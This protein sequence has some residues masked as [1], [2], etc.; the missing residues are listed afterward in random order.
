MGKASKVLPSGVRGRPWVD[1]RS[2]V[3]S[4]YVREVIHSSLLGYISID[5]DTHGVIF[6]S[7]SKRRL[8]AITLAE[9]DLVGDDEGDGW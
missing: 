5:I 2:F 8:L 6:H 7:D 3:Q 9:I 4:F 1:F